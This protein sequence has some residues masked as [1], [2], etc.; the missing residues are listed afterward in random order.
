MSIFGGIDKMQNFW[1]KHIEII[2]MASLITGC[3]IF[4][5]KK[6]VL[7][8]KLS[9]VSV[10]Y[11]AGITSSVYSDQEIKNRRILN[12]I[13]KDLN[14]KIIAITQQHYCKKF[15]YNKCWPQK[16]RFNTYTTYLELL[17]HLHNEKV[18]GWVGFSNGGYYLE[19]LS[20]LTK[21]NVPIISVGAAVKGDNSNDFHVLIGN[22]DMVAYKQA[23]EEQLNFTEYNGKHELEESSLK[24]KLMDVV[25]IPR[26]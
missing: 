10:V 24:K 4:E 7:G 1:L 2:L 9:N 22:K 11:L 18:S 19:K 12:K 6:I 5:P 14:I 16:S 17:G 23:K 3:A 15:N 13:G 21:I 20:N 26:S 25:R 8:N